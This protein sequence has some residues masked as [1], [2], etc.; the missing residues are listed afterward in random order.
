MD[1]SNVN[2][3]HGQIREEVRTAAK[4]AGG[5]IA[6]FVRKLCRIRV[7]ISKNGCQ[8]LN[9]P[10]PLCVVFGLIN[11]PLTVLVAI[12]GVLCDYSYQVDLNGVTF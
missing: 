3:E 9:L 11:L 1:T 6:E 4:Q 5:K 12:A 2:T 10:L 7:R 8:K